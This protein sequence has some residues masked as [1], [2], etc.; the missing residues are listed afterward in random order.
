MPSEK[1]T[2]CGGLFRSSFFS[3]STHLALTLN[4]RI[5]P[6]AHPQRISRRARRYIDPGRL[7][8][9][10]ARMNRRGDAGGNVKSLLN[11]I[12]RSLRPQFLAGGP[13]GRRRKEKNATFCHLECGFQLT[14]AP[15]K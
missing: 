10:H 9:F 7:Q 11:E 14:K 2:S 15:P 4:K 3:S 12:H 8:I 5:V 13:S 6:S 1:T